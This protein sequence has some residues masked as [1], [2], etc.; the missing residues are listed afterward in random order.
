MSYHVEASLGALFVLLN[1]V[2]RFNMPPTNRASTTAVR[3][4]FATLSYGALLVSAYLL[5]LFTPVLVEK[6]R[7]GAHVPEVAAPLP[8]PLLIALLL[9]I[10]LP[11][12]PILEPIDDWTRKAL[13]DM[14]AIPHEARRLAAEMR[15]AP[16][17]VPAHLQA[18]VKNEL[19]RHA[20]DSADAV[21]DERE[22][23]HGLWTK[24][25]ALVL[26]LGELES[27]RRF[28]NFITRFHDDRAHLLHRYEQLAPKVRRWF[29]TA[30]HL[31]SPEIADIADIAL[32]YQTDLLEQCEE[33]IDEIYT[34][35][36]R[37]LLKCELTYASRTTRLRVIG[38][39]L[40]VQRAR[41]TLDRIML[42][43]VSVG[44]VF[45]FG[46]TFVQEWVELL[47]G[48]TPSTEG[49]PSVGLVLSRTVMIST[50]YALSACCAIIPKERWEA[51]RR[52][53]GADRPVFFYFVT[54][55]AAAGLSLIVSFLFGLLTQLD[56]REAWALF[57]VRYPWAL[58]SFTT[59]F[60][61]AWLAD[62]PPAVPAHLRRQR[63]WEAAVQGAVSIATAVVV[64][65]WLAQV[66]PPGAL[67]AYYRLPDP[68]SAL[69]RAAVIGFIIGY[70]VPTWYRQ[71]PR[72]GE[73]TLPQL[74]P[75][76]AMR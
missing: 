48:R 28:A 35:L 2:H 4:Y 7:L 20:F 51:A 11:V 58:M 53:P 62:D 3:Y 23:P 19:A 5:F 42:L 65:A 37:G 72:D 76:P 56:V 44:V 64:L 16:F 15:R 30:R 39:D 34:F 8:E 31:G 71:A 27:D 14:A 22:V 1:A 13:Q 41:M 38:F 12:L 32:Q 70:Q 60:F 61:T 25:T 67:P 47:I 9:T 6:A 24:L 75:V 74:V 45:I 43:F 33:V 52:Q 50:I 66:Q 68:T 17:N 59:A 69:L 73:A 10:L 46:L 49:V 63:W 57:V 54:S 36:S 29:K 21:F 26:Q 55:L 40:T 18:R